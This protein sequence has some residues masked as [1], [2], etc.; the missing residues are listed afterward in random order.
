MVIAEP[1]VSRSYPAITAGW[2]M[3][4]RPVTTERKR[5]H[6][7][8]NPAPRRLYSRSNSRRAAVSAASCSA[9]AFGYRKSSARIARETTSATAVRATHL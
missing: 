7:I 1:R 9:T 4:R 8:R 2:Y 3:A 5:D 6:A